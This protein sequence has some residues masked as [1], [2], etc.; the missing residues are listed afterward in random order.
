[1]K[2]L[3]LPEQLGGPWAHALILT[4]GAN[5]PFFENALWSQFDA[6]CRHKVVLV[7]GRQF[8]EACKGYSQSGLLRHLNQRYIAEGVFAPHAAHAKAILL[9]SADKG[10]LLVGSGNLSLSGYASGGELFTQY[11]YGPDVPDALP[12]FLAVWDLV[13]LLNGRG[14]LGAVAQRH[15]QHVQEGALWLANKWDEAKSPVRHNLRRPFLEQL[16]AEVGSEPVRELWMLAPFLDKNAAAL[17]RL[18]EMLKPR[19]ASLLVQ[20][21]QTSADVAAI[22]RVR[23]R[24]GQLEVK[25]FEL[26]GHR[27]YVHAKLYVIKTQ[28]RAICL[29]GSPNLSAAALLSSDPHGNIELASLLT[30]SVDS[31]DHLLDSLEIKS[32]VT[33]LASLDVVYLSTPSKNSL[34]ET[35]WF[36]IGGEWDGHKLYLGYRGAPPDLARAKL[37]V[38]GQASPLKLVA[39]SPQQVEIEIAPAI[40]T[41]LQRPIAVAVQWEPKNDETTNS[42]FIS[43]RAA[44][45]AELHLADQGETLRRVGRLELDDEDLEQLLFELEDTLVINR[46]S[47][48]QLAG[49]EVVTPSSDETDDGPRLNYSAINYELLRQHPKIQQYLRRGSG[50][51]GL[52]HSR[53]QVLLNAIVEHFQGLSEQTPGVPVTVPTPTGDGTGDEESEADAEADEE[54]HE[55]R[56]L[57]WERR[58]SRMFK[59]FIKRY[60]LGFASRDFQEFVGPLVMAQNFIVFSHL[61]WRLLAK[62][63]LEIDFLTD[64][65]LAVWDAFWGSVQKDGYISS[66]SSEVQAEIQGVL[67]AHEVAGQMLATVVGFD[68]VLAQV[69]RAYRDEDYDDDAEALLG[70]RLQLRDFWR[71]VL[72]RPPVQIEA[73]DLEVA[74]RLVATQNAFEPPRPSVI[75][76]KLARLARLTSRASLTE[77]VARHLGIPANRCY[78]DRARVRTPSARSEET[79]DCLVIN[80][81]DAISDYSSAL[82]ILREWMRTEPRPYYRIVSPAANQTDRLIFFDTVEQTGT[83]YRKDT[84][85]ARDFQRVVMASEPWDAELSQLSGLAGALDVTLALPRTVSAAKSATT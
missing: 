13:K 73:H 51:H 48:W 42:V 53:L 23:Q 54:A 11:D 10:R 67:Q 33:N 71:K 7:D 72:T 16:L 27:T 68:D 12:A 80:D 32:P 57:S 77:A 70:K 45:E 1:V 56:R 75:V 36:L 47:V 61:L 2:P 24:F 63:W 79:V 29:T 52:A 8:L 14:Y 46:R 39:I 58:V 59:S 84:R 64:A 44:L 31:F 40:A 41:L 49:H 26:R 55:R 50:M 17:N 30:G 82:E 6:A 5:F 62:D 22:N 28:R 60:L 21:G 85:E 78:F 18:M 15:L 25:P 76:S 20:K 74:W 66:L 38:G 37:I 34:D 3:E 69:H 35:S 81:A 9:V 4:F 43:N 65:Q 19:R 83:F